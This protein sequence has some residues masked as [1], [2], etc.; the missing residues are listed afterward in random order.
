MR[1]ELIGSVEASRILGKLQ[2][3][4]SPMFMALN[5]NKRGKSPRSVHRMVEDNRLIPV[6]TAPGGRAGA[7]LFRRQ[8]VEALAAKAAAWPPCWTCPASCGPSP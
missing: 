6:L 7:F 3:G 8:D 2:N 1:D 5:R 4:E